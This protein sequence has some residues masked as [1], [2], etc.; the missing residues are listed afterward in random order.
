VK[1][2]ILDPE[3]TIETNEMMEQGQVQYGMQTFDQS[4]MKLY[5]GGMISFEEAMLHASNPDDFDLRVRGITASA[6]RWNDGQET[7]GETQSK[8]PSKRS[9]SDGFRKY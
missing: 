6:D 8:G 3:K 1:E 4:I 7:S 5:K 2:C 9:S